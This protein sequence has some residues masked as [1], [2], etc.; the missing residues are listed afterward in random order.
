MI[1]ASA[2]EKTQ[3][4]ASFEELLTRDNHTTTPNSLSPSNGSIAMA[5]K[6]LI[7]ELDAYHSDPSPAVAS[8]QPVSDEDLLH[9]TA[10]LRGPDGTAYEGSNPRHSLTPND[11]MD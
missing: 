5:A 7:K 4:Q 11:D 2:R 6:R 3:L 8:L 9:L 1:R 10:V